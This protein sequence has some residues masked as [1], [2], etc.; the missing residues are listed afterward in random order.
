[1]Y[2]TA[3]KLMHW[4]LLVV[5]AILFALLL[6]GCAQKHEIVTDTATTAKES[7]SIAVKENPGC[8]KVG[9]V[10]NQQITILERNCKTELSRT[11]HDEWNNGLRV[12]VFGTLLILFGL[13]F[14]LR[15]FDK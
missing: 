15:R 5:M 13:G 4:F 11:E 12:G 14:I 2:K 8:E 7:V 10:A 1:M 9:E 6:T 3:E